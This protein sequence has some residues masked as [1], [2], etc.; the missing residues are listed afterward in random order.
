M[1]NRSAKFASALFASILVGANCAAVAENETKAADDCLTAPK[2][3]VPAGSHWY[4]RIDHANKRQCWYIG[5]EK[6]RSTRDAAAASSPSQ[7]APAAP[8]QLAP[9]AADSVPQ[10]ASASVRKSIANARAEYPAR[11]TNAAPDASFNAAPRSGR[12]AVDNGPRAMTTD[13]F[14]QGSA[15]TSRWPD[16]SG[17]NSSSEPRLAAADPAESPQAGPEAVQQP[18]VAPV[19]RVVADPSMQKQSGSMQMLLLVMVGALSLAGLIGNVIFR[20]G[21]KRRSPAYQIRDGRR[22]IWD[23]VSDRHS[24]PLFAVEEDAPLHAADIAH[25]PPVAEDRAPRIPEDVERRLAEMLQQLARS[26]AT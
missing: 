11:Q 9:A 3:A 13:A 26:E 15:I 19:A 21:R 2:G 5:E 1:S 14:A 24:P 22:A 16:S 18:A 20:F 8:L 10:P 25:E 17:V 12:S 4:Y 6:D 7:A 23:G